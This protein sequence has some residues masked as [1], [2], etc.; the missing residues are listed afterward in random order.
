MLL[1]AT[2]ATGAEEIYQALIEATGQGTRMI[3]DTLQENGMALEEIAACGSLPERN[4]LPMQICAEYARLHDYF[5][6]GENCMMKHL[7]ALKASAHKG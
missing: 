7:K 6:R 5:G 1:G 2:P 3:I 4:K